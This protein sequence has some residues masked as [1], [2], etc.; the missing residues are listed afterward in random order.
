MPDLDPEP[1]TKGGYM[2]GIG[3]EFKEFLL[4]GNVVDLAV[5]VVIGA[6]F[7]A[8]VTSL[9]ENMVTPL[10]AAIGGQPDF[11]EISFTINGSVFGLGLFLNA[12]I[13][14]VI[15]AAVIFFIVVKPMN[16]ITERAKTED[17]ADPTDRKC[18]AC[19]SDVPIAATRCAFCT[20]DLPPATQ[21]EYVTA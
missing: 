14:F 17:P 4:R 1:T 18:P 12:V 15:V 19:L 10:I 6:A 2:R 11:S 13:A 9:V 5:A 7:G 21:S 8:V 16:M 20:S 3:T